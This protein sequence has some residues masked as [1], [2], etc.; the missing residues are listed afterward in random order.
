MSVC[1]FHY[2]RKMGKPVTAYQLPRLGHHCLLQ[3]ISFFSWVITVCCSQSASTDGLSLSAAAYI[4][5]LLGGRTKLFLTFVGTVHLAALECKAVFISRVFD[6]KKST[7]F[8][9]STDNI[10]VE[11]RWGFSG[12]YMLGAG[13]QFSCELKALFN[14]SKL[15]PRNVTLK[16]KYRDPIFNTSNPH[17]GHRLAFTMV[18]ICQLLVT[19]YST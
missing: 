7:T 9:S 8:F 12:K 11:L 14:S 2:D 13:A 4:N 5:K 17:L 3:P 10:S 6:Y 15:S 16:F 1:T 18:Q 19:W